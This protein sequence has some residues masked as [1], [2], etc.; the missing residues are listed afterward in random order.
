MIKLFLC[1]ALVCLCTSFGWAL[2]LRYKNRKAFFYSLDLFNAR[3]INEVSYTKMPLAAFIDK[4]AFKGDFGKF[5]EGKK[6]SGFASGGC[7]FTYLTEDD[8]NFVRDYFVMVGR[9]DALSQKEYLSSVRAET[10]R[11]RTESEKEY[12]RRFQLYVRLSFLL[13]LVAAIALA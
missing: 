13:G 6:K 8:K 5:L 1:I 9:S 2:T 7:D 12:R 3:L 10:E 11:L 4:Y